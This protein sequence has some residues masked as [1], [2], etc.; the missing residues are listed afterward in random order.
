VSAGDLL[1]RVSEPVKHGL[2]IASFA[3]P[4]AIFFNVL[5]SISALLAAVWLVLRIVIGWQEMVLNRRK[6]RGGQ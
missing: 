3:T 1:S 4:V 6:L 2:D 5:P